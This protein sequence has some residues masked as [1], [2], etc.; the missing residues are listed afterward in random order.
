VIRIVDLV[1]RHYRLASTPY[2]LVFDL[3][4]VTFIVRDCL[5]YRYLHLSPSAVSWTHFMGRENDF[6]N[7]AF[8]AFALA[9]LVPLAIAFFRITGIIPL[10][11]NPSARTDRDGQGF[12]LYLH[13]GLTIFLTWA[14]VFAHN[15]EVSSGYDLD[16][17][18]DEI[19]T[20][21]HSSFHA[22]VNSPLF[23]KVPGLIGMAIT[24]GA[25]IFIHYAFQGDDPPKW[26]KQYV[27]RAR[28]ADLPPGLRPTIRSS[29]IVR[30][31][32]GE[33]PAV[34][35]ADL[36]SKK[37]LQRYSNATDARALLDAEM[38][39]WKRNARRLLFVSRERDT[40]LELQV[41]TYY[42]QAIEAALG[43]AKGHKILVCP[44]AS[45]SLVTF[46]N[47]HA[48]IAGK[49]FSA[50]SFDASDHFRDWQQQEE[51]ILSAVRKTCPP[52]SAVAVLVLTEVGY[53]TG[54][55]LPLSSFLPKLRSGFPGI[56]VIVDGRNAMG[57][58]ELRWRMRIGTT[59]FSTHIAGCLQRKVAAF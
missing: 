42:E 13:L 4:F 44:F 53:A 27:V 6:E 52:E 7:M 16:L 11:S 56:R 1:R 8:F 20:L 15:M 14:C 49:E 21:F 19:G 50:I 48:F 57:N 26:L 23:G 35:M 28:L 32:S 3:I 17:R 10:P 22:V 45:P 55:R 43:R 39:D 46:L 58:R 18:N 25:P 24:I 41:F 33:A 2:L 40:D 47:W 5:Y 12:V 30:P 54:R 51:K 59:T 38:D 29:T 37:A 34:P 9:V 36:V 31:G